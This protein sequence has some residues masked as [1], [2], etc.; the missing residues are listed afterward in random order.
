MLTRLRQSFQRG[1]VAFF[2]GSI[3]QTGSMQLQATISAATSGVGEQIIP[4]HPISCQ[5]DLYYTDDNEFGCTHV[6]VPAG[7]PRAQSCIN[8]SMVLLLLEPAVAPGS[9][10]KF[11]TREQLEYDWF[12]KHGEEWE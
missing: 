10:W 12:I 1:D 7:D 2:G 5:E 4:H 3:H 9:E 8:H 6:Q 11:K